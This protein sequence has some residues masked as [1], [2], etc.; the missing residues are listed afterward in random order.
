ML[1]SSTLASTSSASIFSPSSAPS[2]WETHPLPARVIARDRRRAIK[3]LLN[4]IRVLQ[5]QC[6]DCKIYRHFY[7]YLKKDKKIKVNLF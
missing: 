5:S 3:T 6:E 4:F 7:F 1:D 2:P